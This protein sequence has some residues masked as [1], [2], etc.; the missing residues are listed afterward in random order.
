MTCEMIRVEVE[1]EF[2]HYLS[3]RHG[4]EA[5]GAEVVL[6][7]P[8]PAGRVLMITKTFYPDSVFRLPTGVMT[9]GETVAEA[10]TRESQE[11]TG[12]LS[13]PVLQ[14]GTVIIQCCAASEFVEIT[15]HI[16][17]GNQVEGTPSPNDLAEGISGFKEVD[18]SGL[19][20]VADRLQSLPGRWK[21]WGR[22]RAPIHNIVADFLDA[23]PLLT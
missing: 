23:H 17:L 8:R 13:R 12:F 2:V 16:V 7:L 5:T 4:S 18:A 15:S 3:T 1:P 6:V 19:R 11:E 10:F 20:V 14:I 22:F 21:G 9:V